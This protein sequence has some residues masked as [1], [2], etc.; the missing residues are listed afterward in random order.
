MSLQTASH[1]TAGMVALPVC[2]LSEQMTFKLQAA[3]SF[4]VLQEGTSIYEDAQDQ[5]HQH[6][7]DRI[8]YVVVLS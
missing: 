4:L 5:R 2:S 1:K 8:A 6:Q 3:F 7:P